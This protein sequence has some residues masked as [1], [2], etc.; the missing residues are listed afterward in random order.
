[1]SVSIQRAREILQQA[2]LLYSEQ[3]VQAALQRIAQQINA[4]LA[5]QQPLVLAVMSGAAVFSGQLLPLLNCALEFGYVDVSRYGN[6]QSGGAVQWRVEPPEQVRGRVVLVLDDIL[7]EGHTLAAIHRRV[8]ELGAIRVYS[9]VLADKR[10]GRGKAIHA[11]FIGLEL[12]DRFAFGYGM[13]IAGVWRNLP[14][15]YAVKDTNEE[16]E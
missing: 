9:A 11:D 3:Q 4:V 10:H 5:D 2:D 13:D 12:P 16:L 14:A 1:M 8:T 6:A 15:I 7:D